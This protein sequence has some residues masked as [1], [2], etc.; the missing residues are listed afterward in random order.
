[1]SGQDFVGPPVLRSVIEDFLNELAATVS[2]AHTIE[3]VLIYLTDAD[4]EA[5]EK[6]QV[7]RPI[8]KTDNRL[9]R[10]WF[11]STGCHTEFVEAVEDGES[12]ERS[13]MT[14]AALNADAGREAARRAK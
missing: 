6:L 11:C 5:R 14:D 3:R 12:E 10:Y 8:S 9:V 1:M 4:I 2:D 7:L 13:T